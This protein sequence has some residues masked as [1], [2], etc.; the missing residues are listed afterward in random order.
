MSKFCPTPL[1]T[2]Q[3]IEA[4]ERAL[5]FEERLP[6]RSV[7]QVFEATAARLPYVGGFAG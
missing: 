3:D 2:L 5:P 1:R 4:F 6:M 7:Y